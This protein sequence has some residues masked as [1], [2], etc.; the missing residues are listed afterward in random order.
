MNSPERGGEYKLMTN[1]PK[2]VVLLILDGWGY[3]ENADSNAIKGAQT[4]NWD[5]LWQGWPHMLIGTSGEAVGLPD[6][7]MGN[8]EV[9]HLNL[10]AG[11][12]V[13]QEFTR[14][15][16]SISSGEFNANPAMTAAVDKAIEHKGAVHILGLLSP[17]GVHSHEEHIHA[18]ARLAVKRG[19][20]KVYVHAILEQGNISSRKF[21]G[22]P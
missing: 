6:G 20:T 19:A 17:G 14:I 1:R 10:G 21:F 9:G 5:R 12:V 13:Y 22:L 4:P 7:Q 2:P 3:S 16:L 11:R 8:S 18:M 15:S